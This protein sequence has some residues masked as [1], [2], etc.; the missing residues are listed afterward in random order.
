MHVLAWTLL[1]REP[2][3][4]PAAVT[5]AIVLW[6]LRDFELP[7]E[8]TKACRSWGSFQPFKLQGRHARAHNSLIAYATSK[9]PA[10][11][12]VVADD[13]FR[14]RAGEIEGSRVHRPTPGDRVRKNARALLR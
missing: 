1:A 8:L 7:Q 14:T 12:G 5:T 6:T 2:A 3:R 10:Q 4:E 11:D 13:R 9:A